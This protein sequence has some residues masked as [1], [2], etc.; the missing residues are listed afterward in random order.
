MLTAASPAGPAP[1]VQAQPARG[2]RISSTHLL[3]GAAAAVDGGAN[4]ARA[5]RAVAAARSSPLLPSAA[6][7]PAPLFAAASDRRQSTRQGGGN[8]TGAKSASA[9]VVP[10]PKP[11]TAGNTHAKHDVAA[12]AV[13]APPSPLR[14]ASPSGA[15]WGWRPCGCCAPP[16]WWA[17]ASGGPLV[18]GVQCCQRSRCVCAT[19]CA[20]WACQ[21]AH[22]QKAP[23]C[24]M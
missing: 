24:S 6:R 13:S 17:G 14:T 11:N 22:P 3:R 5:T 12:A 9:R 4:A 2:P 10:S 23:G 8:G 16:R 1:T 7:G 15:L 18:G 19:T 20:A 21:K